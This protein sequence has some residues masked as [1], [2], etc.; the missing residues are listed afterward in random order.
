MFCWGQRACLCHEH[1]RTTFGR[2]SL[3]TLFD[4]KSRVQPFITQAGWPR[5]SGDSPGSW[6]LS[7]YHIQLHVG[8]RILN[9]KPLSTEPSPWPLYFFPTLSLLVLVASLAVLIGS[10]DLFSLQTNILIHMKIF[11]YT[12]PQCFMLGHILTD[13]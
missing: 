11:P 3:S 5:A 1:Q 4:M 13:F 2:S 8:S 7:C 9:S 6:L 12:L 10:R